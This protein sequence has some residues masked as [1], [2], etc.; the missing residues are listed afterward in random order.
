MNENDEKLARRAAAIAIVA[1][2]AIACG[3]C[4]PVKANPFDRDPAPAWECPPGDI[5][6][7]RLDPTRP[8]ADKIEWIVLGRLEFRR[9]CRH[10]ACT[11]PTLPDPLAPGKTYARVYL[12]QPPELT[13]PSLLNHE[14]CHTQGWV[15]DDWRD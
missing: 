4:S 8:K 10:D 13:S 5:G 11:Y 2:T 12:Q 14:Y 15:H 9:T 6:G 1:A 7:W 3:L